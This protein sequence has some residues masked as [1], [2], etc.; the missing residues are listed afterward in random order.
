[1]GAAG[2]STPAFGFLGAGKPPSL[3]IGFLATARGAKCDSATTSDTGLT[4]HGLGLSVSSPVGV[5]MAGAAVALPH[6]PFDGASPNGT[7]AATAGR[8]DRG[9]VPALVGLRTT[10]PP[11]ALLVT[12][13]VP[14][15]CRFSWK[16]MRTDE[17]YQS[18]HSCGAQRLKLGAKQHS[19]VPCDGHAAAETHEAATLGDCVFQAQAPTLPPT[20]C[21]P[22]PA[23]QR[24]LATVASAPLLGAALHSPPSG[25]PTS[26]LTRTKVGDTG[27]VLLSGCPSLD[28]V[29]P[30]THMPRDGLRCATIQ[31]RGAA[32]T[33]H[34]WYNSWAPAAGR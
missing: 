4:P 25:A 34:D 8:P 16:E 21:L 3:P 30:A 22:A 19:G 20:A 11:A 23:F 18:G 33:S 5:P 27:R 17:G 29:A 24:S 12:T 32:T 10:W 6:Q 2:P 14:S 13:V 26:P 7:A 28:G 31:N 9:S 15:H 1:M